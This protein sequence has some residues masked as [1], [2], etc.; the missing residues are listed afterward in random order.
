MARKDKEADRSVAE[1]I[2]SID[3][4]LGRQYRAL[5][6][7]QTDLAGWLTILLGKTIKQDKLSLAMNADS[8]MGFSTREDILQGMKQLRDYLKEYRGED[9]KQFANFLTRRV[10][11][12][13]QRKKYALYGAIVLLGVGVYWLRVH[14]SKNSYHLIHN[15]KCQ[16]YAQG[17]D[18]IGIDTIPW[19]GVKDAN[20]SP[21]WLNEGD[22]LLITWKEGE[23]IEFG[24]RYGFSS[25]VR[26]NS[27]KSF[28]EKAKKRDRYKIAPGL[29]GALFYFI[30]SE[31]CCRF[32]TNYAKRRKILSDTPR[33][34]ALPHDSGLGV[35]KNS[36]FLFL[37]VNDNYLYDT[38][39]DSLKIAGD[40]LSRPMK[41]TMEA[42]RN[43]N[44][45]WFYEDNSGYF[46]VY[47]RVYRKVHNETIKSD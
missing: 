10:D 41:A 29:Y 34:V 40:S 16:V 1:E 43:H 31:G 32:D 14:F 37:G 39:I 36:G 27:P 5:N 47:I 26:G 30:S 9:K 25:D 24:R 44:N 28:D 3:L 38:E 12:S 20:I 11:P 2:A 45:N 7:N 15:I 23:T 4:E 21:L 42:Y 18:I 13:L 6:I 8:G 35:V 46:T 33:P 22:S 17:N 19:L